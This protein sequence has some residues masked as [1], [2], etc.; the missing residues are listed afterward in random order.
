MN[1]LIWCNE[2]NPKSV[3]FAEDFKNDLGKCIKRFRTD[4]LIQVNSNSEQADAILIILDKSDTSDSIFTKSLEHFL[5][6]GKSYIVSISPY[7]TL[8]I[9]ASKL[10]QPYI[11]WDKQ[12]ETGEFRLF[13]NNNDLVSNSWEKITD[14]AVELNERQINTDKVEEKKYVYLSQDDVSHNVDREN[15]KRDL[16]DL[17]FEVL[18]DKTFSN[19]FK[20]ST[21]QIEEALSKSILVIH[22]IPPIYNIHFPDHHLSLSEHQCNVS[23]NYLK[24]KVGEAIRI[25]WISSA[26]DITDEENQVFIEKIQRDNEQTE[27][28]TILKSS[29]EELKKFYRQQLEIG[30]KELQKKEDI[31]DVYLISDSSNGDNSS[32]RTSVESKK[33]NLTSGFDGITYNQ[34]LHNLAKARIAL[35]QYSSKNEQWLASK[36]NDILKSK[37]LDFAK[38]FEKVILVDSSG[39]DDY[40]QFPNVFTD[41][42]NDL[43]ELKSFPLTN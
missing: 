36:V 23:V 16:S 2:K 43:A 11:F 27:G 10:P 26:Y 30:S 4:Y 24:A 39:E 35:L 3:Q 1:I 38:P 28:T 9:D 42:I 13:R 14:V 25:I 29:I 31:V 18:P 19:D 12:Y 7:Q 21:V 32:I 41:V 17:G 22:I 20:E 15:I 37:G 34:H 5:S 8:G 40:Q 6:K 33:L